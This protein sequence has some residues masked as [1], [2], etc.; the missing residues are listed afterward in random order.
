MS[1]QPKQLNDLD[2]S[3]TT[4]PNPEKSIT[5][6][7][8]K[9]MFWRLQLFQVSWNYERMQSLAYAYTMKPVLEKLY[10]TKEERSEALNR[11]LEFFNTHPTM[12]API[13]GINTALEEQNGNESGQGVSGIKT[14]LMGPL[15]G[16]GDSI[17]WLTWMPIVMSIGAAFAMDGNI[18][19]P[20]LALILFNLVNIPLKWYGLKLGYNKGTNFLQEAGSTGIVQRYTTMA[21]ILGIIVIGGLI[22]QMVTLTTPFVLTVGDTEVKFQE[23]FDGILPNLLP[24]MVTL[25]SFF[26]IKKGKNPVVILLGT[27]VVCI[28]GKWIGIF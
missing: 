5:S 8:L 4:E 22:P 27:I 9:S 15:A 16:I 21:T 28:L 2:L 14:G 19:G 7:D 1:E 10:K 12:A 18:L 25:S 13:L 11:H 6:K 23:I 26:L 3:D 24:L 20:I 17:I